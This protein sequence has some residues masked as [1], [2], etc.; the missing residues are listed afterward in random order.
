LLNVLLQIANKLGLSN[1]KKTLL[2]GC[3]V[4]RFIFFCGCLDIYLVGWLVGCAVSCPV[5]WKVKD[6]FSRCVTN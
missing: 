3:L 6:T 1:K 5:S 4:T 2:I